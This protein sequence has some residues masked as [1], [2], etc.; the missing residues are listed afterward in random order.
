[1]KMTV[2]K[3]LKEK[4]RLVGRVRNL[5]AIIARENA[6][7]EGATRS[8]DVK[9]L[10]VEAFACMEKLIAVKGAIAKANHPVVASIV[11]LEEIKS[12]LTLLD[13][14]DTNDE[15]RSSY[16]SDQPHRVTVVISTADIMLTRQ[17]LQERADALQD[18]LDEFNVCA[19]VELT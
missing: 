14:I 3:A 1:M 5:M 17:R 4:S 9:A 13:K 11:E 8:I 2:A 7:A 10:E 6:K 16:R 12:M 15:P 19:Q 18:A